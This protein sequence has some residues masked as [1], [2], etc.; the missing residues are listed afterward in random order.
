MGE[1][2]LTQTDRWFGELAANYPLP[3]DV[4]RQLRCKGYVVIKGAVAQD[5]LAQLS[6]AYDEAVLT[7]HPADVSVR[8]STRVSDFVNRGHSFDELY[9]YAPLLAACCQTIARPFKLSTMLARTLEPGA[10]AQNLHADFKR[11]DE[12]WPMVGFIYMVDEFRGDNGATRFVPGSHMRS[13]GPDDV[14][15]DA[16][17]DYDG[18]ALACG[19]AGSVIIYNGSVWHGHTANRSG[20]RRRS[21][22]GAFIRR[23]AQAAVN[24]SARMRPETLHRVGNLAKYLLDL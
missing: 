13:C 16:A 1:I 20:R 21:I 3:E 19:P 6:E 4:A 14:M 23:D 15:K 2:E 10:P 8:S 22:Q 18:Q 12:G 5:E 9:I 11:D 17:A 24:W 7:A